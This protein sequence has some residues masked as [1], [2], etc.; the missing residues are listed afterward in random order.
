MKSIEFM[1]WLQGYFEISQA[2]TI[3]ETQCQKIK[4]HLKMVEITDKKEIWPFCS[5]LNGF[6]DAIESPAP[7]D[8]QTEKIKNRLNN[9][10]EHVA[11]T[12]EPVSYPNPSERSEFIKC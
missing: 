6:L 3:N 10:F 12:R 2:K 9:I 8:N 7:N 1:Y 4:N 11:P 5:W